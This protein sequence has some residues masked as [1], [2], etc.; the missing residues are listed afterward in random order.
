MI[1]FRVNKENFSVKGIENH[2]YKRIYFKNNIFYIFL[3]IF[4]LQ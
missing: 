1:E 3:D 2:R 4:E